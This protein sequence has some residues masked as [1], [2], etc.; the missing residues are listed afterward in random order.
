M[1]SFPGLTRG[2]K[3]KESGLE[4]QENKLQTDSDQK[5]YNLLI[6]LKVNKNSGALDINKFIKEDEDLKDEDD[7]GDA[8]F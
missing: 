8:L 2:F 6:E 3:D 5:L 7:L 1:I 4:Y